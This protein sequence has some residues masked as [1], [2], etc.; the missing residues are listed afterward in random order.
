MGHDCPL[1]LEYH[2]DG[3]L[4]AALARYRVEQVRR[5]KDKQMASAADIQKLIGRA[6]RSQAL[7]DR[8]AASGGNAETVMNNFEQTMNRFDAQFGQMSE[9]EKQLA[10]MIEVGNGGPPLDETFPAPPVVAPSSGSSHV[11]PPSSG[12]D[13]ATGDPIRT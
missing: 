10:A 3:E 13:H 4:Y 6:K 8:A 9:Y 7:T 5:A 2:W 1:K 12:F 11:T